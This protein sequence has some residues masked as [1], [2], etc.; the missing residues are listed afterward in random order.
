MEGNLEIDY[1]A[2][3]QMAIGEGGFTP[4][5]VDE[6]LWLETKAHEGSLTEED[7]KRILYRNF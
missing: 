2:E 7:K 4:E 3:I 5:Q 1:I 6:V